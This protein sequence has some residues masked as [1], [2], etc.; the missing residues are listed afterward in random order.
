MPASLLCF[1]AIVM[2]DLRLC[3]L[4]RAVDKCNTTRDCWDYMTRVGTSGYFLT[5][6]LL[7]FIFIEHVSMH[8]DSYT[9]IN[10]RFIASSTTVLNQHFLFCCLLDLFR[11]CT[12][13][14]R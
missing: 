9:H 2:S 13:G 6:Q 12:A 14:M 7:Y 3:F 10:Y 1:L 11:S 8:S 5:H 4:V